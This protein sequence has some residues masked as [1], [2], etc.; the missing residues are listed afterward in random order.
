MLR[1][2]EQDRPPPGRLAEGREILKVHARVRSNSIATTLR[3]GFRLEDSRR[4]LANYG[5]LQ[6][7][8][9]PFVQ[10]C[11]PRR[12]V[13]GGYASNQPPRSL[14]MEARDGE[15]EVGHAP[16]LMWQAGQ[17]RMGGACE[18]PPDT[19]MSYKTPRGSQIS[20]SGI[21]ITTKPPSCF[22]TACRTQ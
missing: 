20:P 7:G 19:S 18:I 8:E 13:Q 4:W 10:L 22:A 14:L 5:S 21:F 15:D 3:R 9:R 6:G 17:W 11:L 1:S 16:C 2:V 12:E